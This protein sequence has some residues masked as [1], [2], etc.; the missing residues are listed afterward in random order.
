MKHSNRGTNSNWL[1]HGNQPS[2]DQR[3]M[4]QSPRRPVKFGNQVG[5]RLVPDGPL[6]EVG[7][8]DG[9]DV[10][11]LAFPVD[12]ITSPVDSVPT[13]EPDREAISV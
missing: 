7:I 6:P 3:L 4:Q 2:R 8:V 10:C 5:N 13:S 1:G 12:P 11:V 9:P